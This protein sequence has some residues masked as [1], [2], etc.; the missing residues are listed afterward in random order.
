M[1]TPKFIFIQPSLREFFVQEYPKIRNFISDRFDS[2]ETL[3]VVADSNTE[4]VDQKGVL[5]VHPSKFQSYQEHI[6]DFFSDFNKC[7]SIEEASEKF[8]AKV[9]GDNHD[10]C[11]TNI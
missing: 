7:Q 10:Q 1:D 9:E 3:V 2:S 11:I 4:Y 6:F 8:F 5:Y